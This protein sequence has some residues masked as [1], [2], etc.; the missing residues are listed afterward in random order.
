MLESKFQ[1]RFIKRLKKEFPGCVLLRNDPSQQQGMLDWTL[2]WDEFWAALEIKGSLSASKQP[3]QEYF[4]KMLNKMS[5]AAFVCPEN[6][7]EV[8]AALQKAFASRKSACVPQP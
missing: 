4:V 8:I 5:F 3:N 7:E 2:L 6:E 1:K